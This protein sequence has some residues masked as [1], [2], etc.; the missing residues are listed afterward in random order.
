METNLLRNLLSEHDGEAL[1]RLFSDTFISINKYV[2]DFLKN[3]AV[4]SVRLYT[5]STYLV[6]DNSDGVDLLG[7]FTL[8][9]G[10]TSQNLFQLG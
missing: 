8:S 5:S 9:A 7:Y 3:K 1:F 10:Y 2:E 4:H 6:Y